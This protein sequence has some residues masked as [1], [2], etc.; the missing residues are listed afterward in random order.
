[1]GSL[2]GTA[3]GSSSFFHQLNPHW[4]LQLEVM[5]TYLPDTGN[6]GW[7]NWCGAGTPAPE[8]SLPNFYPSHVCEGPAHSIPVPLLPVSMDV[9]SLIL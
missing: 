5:G 7:G 4:I 8:I 6:L 3:W 1:M 2:R 9:V